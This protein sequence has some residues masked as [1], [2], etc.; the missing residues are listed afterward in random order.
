[1]PV[2]FAGTVRRERVLNLSLNSFSNKGFKLSILAGLGKVSL[3]TSFALSH[4]LYCSKLR[5][6]F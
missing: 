3:Q 6:A 1:M 4:F 2:K 5:Y